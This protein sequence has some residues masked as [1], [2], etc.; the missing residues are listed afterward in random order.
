VA[1][2]HPELIRAIAARGHEVGLHGWR[3]EHLDRLSARELERFDAGLS[4]TEAAITELVG[5]RPLG[6]RAPYLLGPSFHQRR[7]YELLRRHGYRWTSNREIRHP[8]ELARPDRIRTDRLWRLLEARP[9]LLAGRGA[10]LSLLA[11]NAKLC[12][13]DPVGGS[14]GSAIRWLRSG[15]PPFLRGD[16]LEIPLYGPLDCDLLGLPAPSQ[17][18]PAN[19]WQYAA[20][21]LR[22]ALDAPRP[23]TMLTFHDWLIT[24]GNRLSLLDH[25]LSRLSAAAT[26]AVTVRDCL[27]PLIDRATDGATETAWVGTRRAA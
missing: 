20:F 7:A 22:Q 19:L 13:A 9:G 16:L 14:T 8:V 6:F 4:E 25:A 17:P 5:A 26:R 11:L 21:A 1:L 27:D 24:G 18:T 23:L 12:R 15:F 3:H 10:A 2:S